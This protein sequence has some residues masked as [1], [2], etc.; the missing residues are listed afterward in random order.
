MKG[1]ENKRIIENECG[2]SKMAMK[3]QKE[4]KSK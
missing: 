2:E 1:K 4:L 3:G